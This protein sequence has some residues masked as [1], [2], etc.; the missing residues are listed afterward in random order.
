MWFD[1]SFP[2]ERFSSLYVKI[3]AF[4]SVGLILVSRSGFGFRLLMLQLFLIDV[5]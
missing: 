3:I 4:V 5:E 2:R 1:D